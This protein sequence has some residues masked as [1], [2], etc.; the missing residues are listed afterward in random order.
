MKREEIAEKLCDIIREVIEENEEVNE[1]ISSDKT[2]R[3]IGIN[4]VQF[5]SIIVKSEMEFDIEFDDD[6]LN[7]D[8]FSSIESIVDYI[9]QII[10]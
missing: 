10:E 5:I 6:L 3:E 1:K 4:S 8:R 9:E 7:S 2:L